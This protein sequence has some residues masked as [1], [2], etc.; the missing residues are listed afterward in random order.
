VSCSDVSCVPD[1]A[2]IAASNISFVRVW[3]HIVHLKTQW[4]V[5]Y[6]LSSMLC[7]VCNSFFS[8][9]SFRTVIFVA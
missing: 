3:K 4:E 6:V 1:V 2:S 7:Q 8:K 5:Y 9:F